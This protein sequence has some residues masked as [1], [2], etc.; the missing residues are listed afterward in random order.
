LR[1]VAAQEVAH[2][3]EMN[4]SHRFWAVVERLYPGWQDQRDWLRRHGSA[5]HAVRFT[6]YE[7][8]GD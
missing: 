5:L 6:G 8:A 1:Y 2:M 4:H 3:V 7:S